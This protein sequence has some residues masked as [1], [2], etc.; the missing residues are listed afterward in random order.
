MDSIEILRNDGKIGPIYPGKL[1][2]LQAMCS[3]SDNNPHPGYDKMYCAEAGGIYYMDYYKDYSKANWTFKRVDGNTSDPMKDGDIV[4]IYNA[5]WSSAGLT[6]Y[7]ESTWSVY[8]IQ[9]PSS[10]SITLKTRFDNV[11]R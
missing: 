8:I 6:Q 4:T 11:F 3:G 9:L 5:K 1:F 10:R 7:K 2:A